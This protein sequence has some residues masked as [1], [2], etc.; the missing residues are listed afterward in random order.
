MLRQ[1]A[2][3]RKS[4]LR[5]ELWQHLVA[6]KKKLKGTVFQ[7]ETEIVKKRCPWSR[8]RRIIKLFCYFAYTRSQ[9]RCFGIAI[10][11]RQLTNYRAVVNIW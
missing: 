11:L 5:S 3:P 2:L 6:K 8:H 10:H 7:D 1:A 4:S 9:T